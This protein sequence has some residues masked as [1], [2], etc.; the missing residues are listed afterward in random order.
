M[1]IKELSERE[2]AV[3]KLI[4][5]GM[6]TKEIASRIEVSIKT[7]ETH[8]RNLMHKLKIFTIAGLTKYA[9]RNGLS[10]LD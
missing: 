3:L 10:S 1:D 6:S 5:D 9:I 2:I 8:R 4:A 7:A